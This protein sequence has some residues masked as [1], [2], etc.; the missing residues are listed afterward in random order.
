MSSKLTQ[1]LTSFDNQKCK[2]DSPLPTKPCNYGIIGKKGCGK[3]SVMLALIS[4]PESPWYKFFHLIFLISPT[5]S[6]DDKLKDLVDDLSEQGQYYNELNDIVLHDIMTKIDTKKSKV[7]SKKKKK[8]LQFLII[9]DDCIHQVKN[10][11]MLQKLATQNRHYGIY[12]IYLLQKYNTYMPP[13]VRS[14]LDL[15]SIFHSD[16]RKE[17]DSFIEEIGYDEDILRSFYDFSTKEQYSF[18][19]YNCYSLPVKFYK[20]FDPIEFRR[21]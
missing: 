3:T 10:C 1:A 8:E 13:L 20:K 17:I 18:L 14:N 6:R 4:R 19:H 11:K 16:N 7:K 21:N 12:N 2:N 15:I 5:A 9:Y